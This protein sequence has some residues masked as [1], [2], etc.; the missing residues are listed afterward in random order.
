MFLKNNENFTVK[1]HGNKIFLAF[2]QRLNVILSEPGKDHI[3][4]KLNKV[5]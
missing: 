3:I 1:K 2:Q 4:Y 5:N